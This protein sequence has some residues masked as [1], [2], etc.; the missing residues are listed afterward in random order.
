LRERSE[1]LKVERTTTKKKALKAK[2][3]RI[4]KRELL[5]GKRA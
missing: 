4:T 2:G 3:A 5:R 1:V